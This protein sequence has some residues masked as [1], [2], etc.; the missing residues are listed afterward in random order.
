MAFRRTRRIYRKRRSNRART[1]TRSRYLPRRRYRTRIPSSV[2]V[3]RFRRAG[4]SIQQ[5]IATNSDGY[6]Y[7]SVVANGITDING[8]QMPNLSEF[9]SLYDQYKI[10][11]F[12]YELTPR[13]SGLDISGDNTPGLPTIYWVYDVD[14]STALTNI[15]QLMERP[16]VRKRVIKGAVRLTVKYPSVAAMIYRTATTTGYTARKSPWIDMIDPIVPHYGIKW[17]IAGSA[18]TTY[19]FD[20]RVTWNFLCKNPR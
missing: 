6:A 7:G 3:H 18:S 4:F 5:G 19:T 1:S 2:R 15:T 13:W 9:T 20:V 10:L 16:N 14:D 12:T 17:V 11:N 8:F